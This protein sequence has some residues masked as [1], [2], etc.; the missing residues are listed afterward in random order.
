MRP[1]LV[2]AAVV[3][4]WAFEATAAEP[5]SRPNVLVILADDQGRL[6]GNEGVSA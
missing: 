4:L 6:A 3:S 5:P 1:F 2:T